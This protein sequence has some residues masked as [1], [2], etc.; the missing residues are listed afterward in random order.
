MVVLTLVLLGASF[1]ALSYNYT[2]AEK[3]SELE[4]RA[5]VMAELSVDY[6]REEPSPGI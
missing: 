2:L 6:V 4:D 1:F 3:R 5:E